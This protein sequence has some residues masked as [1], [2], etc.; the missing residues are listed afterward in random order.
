MPIYIEMPKLSDTMTEGTL[1]KW[2]KQEGDA[3]AMDEAIAEVETDK[4]TMEM[5]SFDEGILHK[6]YV[7]EG[8]A[9]PLGAKLALLLQDGEEPPADADSPPASEGTPAA[10]E[11]EATASEAAPAETKSAAKSGDSGDRVKASPLAKKI[12]EEKGV[13]LSG[14]EGTGPGG[15]IV[16]TDVLSAGSGA[17]KS[18]PPKTRPAPPTGEDQRIP[19]TGMRRVISERLLESKTSI[20]H[21]YLHIEVDAAPLM[22]ARKQINAEAEKSGGN[23]FTVNDFVL[24]AAVKAATTVPAVNASFDGDAI[25]Q[26]G[27]VNLAVAV[28]VEQGLVT[29][30]IR[31]AQYLSFEE[32]SLTMKELAEKAR[33]KKLTPDEM[34]GGTMT[35]SNLG[36]YGIDF[37]DAIINPPQSLIL[38]VGAIVKKPVVN[39]RDEI[40]PGLRLNIGLSGDHRVVDGAVGAE[41]LAALRKYLEQ[42]ILMLA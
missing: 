25:L 13:D 19:L 32:L 37:F 5:Q 20:P 26:Y 40:V 12:A 3:V 6:I 39:E 29:P 8:Q 1:V 7:H 35:I 17:K 31:S 16:K 22:A 15:R 9:V 2:L 4:A 24:K 21:F 41:Y 28:A 11:K 18:A 14:I 27:D 42:P 10:E 30:V 38:S 33:T 34:Q 23:K 36:S